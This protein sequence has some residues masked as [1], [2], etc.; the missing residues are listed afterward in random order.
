MY[1]QAAGTD[2]RL[3]RSSNVIHPVQVLIDKHLVKPSTREAYRDF[4][5]AWFARR[6]DAPLPLALFCCGFDGHWIASLNRPTTRRK[7]AARN[8]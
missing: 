1:K 2:S 4:G 6:S 8:T 5:D 3:D 7:P